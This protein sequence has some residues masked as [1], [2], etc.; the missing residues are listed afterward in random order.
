MGQ[1]FAADIFETALEDKACPD[2]PPALEWS[3][4]FDVCALILQGKI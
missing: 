4:Y 3:R 1:F 2:T